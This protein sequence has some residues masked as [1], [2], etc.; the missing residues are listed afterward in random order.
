M[1]FN[2]NPQHSRHRQT[3]LTSAPLLV[4]SHPLLLLV[5]KHALPLLNLNC[6]LLLGQPSL[7][8]EADLNLIS[9]NLRSEESGEVLLDF[10]EIDPHLPL[11]EIGRAVEHNHAEDFLRPLQP[12]GDGE[13]DRL[14]DVGLCE[15][16]STREDPHAMRLIEEALKR[17]ANTSLRRHV[18]HA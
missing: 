17:R 14:V 6:L 2:N 4:L 16:H 15:G 11:I 9:M 3:G 5:N 13:R 7:G 8:R 1:Y 18:E 10:E 12:H